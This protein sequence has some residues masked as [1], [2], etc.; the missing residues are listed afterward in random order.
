MRPLSRAAL[1][2]LLALPFA[3]PSLADS[4]DGEWCNSDGLRLVIEGRTI[5]TPGG[6]KT[7]GQYSRHVFT[8]KA[9][10]GDADAGADVRLTLMNEITV[11]HTSSA[12]PAMQVWRKC[13][14]IS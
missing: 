12:S 10:S 4:I 7:E 6:G 3:A 8:Y 1:L 14:H 9:P 5:T 13:K 11:H 2:S